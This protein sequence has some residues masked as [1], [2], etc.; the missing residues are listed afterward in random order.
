MKRFILQQSE[1]PNHWVCTDKINKIVCV[2]ENHKYNDTQKFTLLENF[3][4]ENYME[5]AHFASEMGEW[6]KKNHYDKIF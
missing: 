1:K 3:E 4:E 2:F 6:L 5:L